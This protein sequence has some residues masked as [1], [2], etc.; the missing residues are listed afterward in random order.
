[1]KRILTAIALIAMIGSAQA[2]YRG[3]YGHHGHHAPRVVHHHG[4]GW[5]HVIAP[6]I[7][8]GVVGAAIANRPAQ[9]EPVPVVVQ[10]VPQ[11]G[12]I[13][14]CPPGTMPFERQGW[15]RNQY[16][17]YIQSTYIECK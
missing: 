1:M 2:G 15:V 16:N 6:L 3:P 11:S 7:I 13:I 10:S 14:T 8:G 5:G 17:Q 12:Q 9:A 4:G